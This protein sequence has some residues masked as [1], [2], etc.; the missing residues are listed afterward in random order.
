MSVCEGLPHPCSGRWQGDR[1][2]QRRVLAFELT[3]DDLPTVIQAVQAAA[4]E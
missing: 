4:S 1:R 2:D 3:E